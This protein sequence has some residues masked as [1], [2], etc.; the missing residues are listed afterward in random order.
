MRKK[1]LFGLIFAVR[2]NSFFFSMIPSIVTKEDDGSGG[3]C[4]VSSNLQVTLDAEEEEVL[5]VCFL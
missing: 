2:S 3:K 4:L 5:R 1:I